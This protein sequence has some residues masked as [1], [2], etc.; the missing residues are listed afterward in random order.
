MNRRAFPMLSLPTAASGFV[1]GEP[2]L[3]PHTSKGFLP[4]SDVFIFKRIGQRC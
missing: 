1:L 4:A 3:I 2:Y